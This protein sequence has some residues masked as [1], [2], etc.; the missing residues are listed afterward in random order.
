MAEFT[1][2]TAAHADE[3]LGQSVVSGVVNSSGHLILTRDN[4]STIDAGDFTQIVSDILDDRVAAALDTRLPAAIAGTTVA[5]GTVTGVLAL[6]ELNVDN[7]LN[8]M[9]KVTLGGAVTLDVS[10][11]PTGIRTNTQFILRLQQDA[12]GGRTFTVTGFKK[13]MGS[14]PITTTPNAIDMV[15]FVYDGTNWLVGL[16][17]SDFK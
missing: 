9:V 4:G 6:P 17:G 7:I 2:I 3:I 16:M 14:L 5:K 10:A 1:G 11:L 12:T 8:A 13:S 15:V